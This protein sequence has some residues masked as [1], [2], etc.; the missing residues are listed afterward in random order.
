MQINI[1]Y[2]ERQSFQHALN[3]NIQISLTY[4]EV[5]FSANAVTSSVMFI[6]DLLCS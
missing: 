2:N 4:S 3:V 6:V 1:S 5:I